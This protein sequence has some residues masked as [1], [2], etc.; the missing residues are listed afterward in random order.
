[1]TIR[2]GLFG[3][4]ASFCVGVVYVVTAPFIVESKEAARLQ[5]LYELALPLLETGVIGVPLLVNLPGTAPATLANPLL[6][7]PITDTQGLIGTIFPFETNEGYGGRIQ[8]LIALDRARQII[9]VRA[10]DHKET[11][12]LGDQIELKHSGWILE[13]NQLKYSDIED[14]AWA[15]KKDGGRFDIFTGATITPRAV[16]DALRDTLAFLE[17]HPEV[18]EVGP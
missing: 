9:G 2:L 8:L 14:A 18:L 12:G 15:V 4:I 11:P 1:M 5:H 3:L 6:I 17:N 13:F 7:T 16:V 10:T